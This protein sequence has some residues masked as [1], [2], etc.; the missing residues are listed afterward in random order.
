MR[1]LLILGCSQRKQAGALMPAWQRYDGPIW[2]S[3]R[4]RLD[5][6][7]DAARAFSG[8]GADQL[9]ILAISARF[10]LISAWQ[11]IPDYDQRLD[12]RRKAMLRRRGLPNVLAPIVDRADEIGVIAGALYRDLLAGMH[13]AI[14]EACRD[15]GGEGIG[16]QRARLGCWLKGRFA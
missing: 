16:E 9:D 12:G 6:L 1:H 11:P 15:T 8:T 14:A 13:P 7:P 4:L 10:G 5:E 3:L 2:Q